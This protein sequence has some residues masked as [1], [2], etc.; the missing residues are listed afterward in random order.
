MSDTAP[1]VA[2][3][4]LREALESILEITQEEHFIRSAD[5]KLYEI[6]T[7]ASL[8]L[9]V[10]AEPSPAPQAVCYAMLTECPTC[11]NDM[12]KCVGA[13]KM[14]PKAAA[15]LVS[16]P[17]VQPT[18][19]ELDMAM[20]I[21]RLA[22]RLEPPDSLRTQATEYLKR[23]GLIGSPLREA[24]QVDAPLPQQVESLLRWIECGAGDISGEDA[25]V[26]GQWL[27]ALFAD[28]RQRAAEQTEFDD[29]P[30]NTHPD[31]PHGFNRN[32]SH[33]AGRYVCDC[34]GWT[35]EPMNGIDHEVQRPN[36]KTPAP[37]VLPLLPEDRELMEQMAL[38]LHAAYDRP[39][40]PPDAKAILDR[41]DARLSNQPPKD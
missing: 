3:H 17:A 9:A 11:K 12:R 10:P 38:W 37:A 30:C 15:P 28:R 19:R 7:Y 24:V 35:P 18:Q 22:R 2:S 29:F 26:A 41:V 16:E 36:E 34:E 6:R 39:P 1:P 31:A 14:P 25:R 40:Q 21:K 32:A 27:R 5:S 13:D 20:L 23:H 33:N 8:A 4:E